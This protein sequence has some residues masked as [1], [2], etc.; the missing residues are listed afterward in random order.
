MTKILLNDETDW[1]TAFD[2]RTFALN[3]STFLFE[4]TSWTEGLFA[5]IYDDKDTMFDESDVSIVVREKKPMF[6]LY[7]TRNEL[8]G[9]V[10]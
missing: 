7:N 2:T 1:Y 5:F 3:T 4:N 8:I 6:L 9:Y 10:N